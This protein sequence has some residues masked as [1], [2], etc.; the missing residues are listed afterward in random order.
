MTFGMTRI[1]GI[2]FERRRSEMSH[3]LHESH[4]STFLVAT[5][6]RSN[7]LLKHGT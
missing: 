7:L 3:Q 5:W 1:K 6:L 4:V 2:L